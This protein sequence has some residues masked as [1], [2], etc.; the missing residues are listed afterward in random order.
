[1]ICFNNFSKIWKYRDIFVFIMY[2]LCSAYISPRLITNVNPRRERLNQ[3]WNHGMHIFFLEDAFKCHLWDA[4]HFVTAT[5]WL[6]SAL[7]L[8][9]KPVNTLTGSPH[10]LWSSLPVGTVSS[11]VWLRS[12]QLGSKMPTTRW[13]KWRK[14]CITHTVLLWRPRQPEWAYWFS[15]MTAWQD[16]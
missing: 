15:H 3:N 8:E 14:W 6:C 12:T 2:R 9:C 13:R 4:G 10:G 16:R 1:M 11:P 5:M 7:F